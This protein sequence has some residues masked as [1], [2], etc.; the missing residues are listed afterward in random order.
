MLAAFYVAAWGVPRFVRLLLA[1]LL[2]AKKRTQTHL[3]D[4]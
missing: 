2:Q 4:G 3:A 1:A